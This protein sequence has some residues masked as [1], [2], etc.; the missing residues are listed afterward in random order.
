MKIDFGGEKEGYL[1]EIHPLVNNHMARQARSEN[2]L[3]HIICNTLIRVSFAFNRSGPFP[4][5]LTSHCVLVAR[6][7]DLFRRP[8]GNSYPVNNDITG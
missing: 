8:V 4:A 2:T 3:R 1:K 6:S 5:R 7:S